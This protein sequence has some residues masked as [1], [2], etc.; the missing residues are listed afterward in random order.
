LGT[1]KKSNKIWWFKN[2]FVNLRRY[3]VKKTMKFRE[4]H[5][6]ISGDEACTLVQ[7]STGE[8]RFGAGKASKI[9][10]VSSKGDL[11]NVTGDS[12][13]VAGNPYKLAGDPA[14]VAGYPYK[15]AGNPAG[16]A[17]YP[18]RLVGDP[19]GVAGD[20]YRLAGD[21]AGVAGDPYKLAGGPVSAV[22]YGDLLL[23]Y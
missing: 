4:R 1:E 11:A 22:V 14:G 23:T 13:N 19:A 17:G 20:P 15:L 6:E 3:L 9:G 7:N 21:P 18:Y 2:I 10:W 5:L 8:R 16:V 12:V